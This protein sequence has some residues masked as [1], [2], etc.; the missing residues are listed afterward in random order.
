MTTAVD[1]V[2]KL[3]FIH[4]LSNRAY[5]STPSKL[6]LNTNP[7]KIPMHFCSIARVRVL[8]SG[9]TVLLAYYREIDLVS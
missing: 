6:Q 8:S 7:T 1:W 2:V 3:H 5:P 4:F 9:I